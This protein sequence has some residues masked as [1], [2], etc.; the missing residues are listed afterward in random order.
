MTNKNKTTLAQILSLVLV[1]LLLI[2]AVGVILKFTNGGNEDFKTFYLEQDGEKILASESQR[3]FPAGKE[4]RFDVKYTFDIGD[5]D[6]PKDY[7]VKIVPNPKVNF[8]YSVDGKPYSWK[9]DI[10]ELSEYFKLTKKETY[11]TFTVSEDL[12]TKSLLEKLYPNKEITFESDQQ[13]VL[14]QNNLY[15]LVVSSYNEAV[16]YRITFGL[17]SGYTVRVQSIELDRD[18]LVF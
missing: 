8:Q 10:S 3:A 2:A 14:E 5:K 4:F 7:S 16:T 9:G 15:Q 18:S 1:A 13:A 11:F 6:S 17:A 12:T